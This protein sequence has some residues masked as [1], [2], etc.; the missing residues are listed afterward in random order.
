[1][2]NSVNQSVSALLIAPLKESEDTSNEDEEEEIENEEE[3]EN[4][5]ENEEEDE[6]SEEESDSE[7]EDEDMLNRLRFKRKPKTIDT[8]FKYKAPMAKLEPEIKKDKLKDQLKRTA[9][10]R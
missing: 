1:M 5:A 10:I 8:N 6:S 4:E 7:S 9:L 2:L 3:D